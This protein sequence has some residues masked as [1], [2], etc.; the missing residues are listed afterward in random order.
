MQGF[1][2]E[3]AKMKSSEKEE[4]SSEIMGMTEEQKMA[5]ILADQERFLD[6]SYPNDLQFFK[7]C[8][9]K[10]LV[11][12]DDRELDNKKMIQAHSKLAVLGYTA[13]DTTLN[14][15]SVLSTKLPEQTLKVL[16][17]VSGL[18]RR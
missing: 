2:G 16:E 18:Q 7:A 12:I 4:E 10:G 3:V 5:I 11:I 1:K 9:K 13:K 8:L 15:S 6:K 14:I 17:I